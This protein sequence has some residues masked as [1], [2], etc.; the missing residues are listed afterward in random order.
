M[1]K[2]ITIIV[3]GFFVALVP[4]LGFP[5]SWKTLL[6]VLSGVSIAVL[7]FLWR[8]EVRYNAGSS[9]VSKSRTNTD[10]YIEN[11]VNLETDSSKHD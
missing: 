8:R 5:G 7:T 3:L 4:F 6:L 2:S 11:D 10:V 9:T 1:T